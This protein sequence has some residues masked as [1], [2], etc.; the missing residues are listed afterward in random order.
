MII[1]NIINKKITTK[2]TNAKI[3]EIIDFC[4]L[5]LSSTF[6]SFI[7]S[8]D[9]AVNIPTI[10]IDIRDNDIREYNATFE[11]ILYFFRFKFITSITPPTI[12][13]IT[14]NHVITEAH[15]NFL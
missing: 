11:I 12:T 4:L 2:L 9:I 3:E 8:A 5:P 1:E 7:S 6:S 15:T 14:V 13:K 10:K